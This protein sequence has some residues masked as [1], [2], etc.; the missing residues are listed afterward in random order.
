M[1]SG[2]ETEDEDGKEV[3][4]EKKEGEED[5][6]EEEGPEREENEIKGRGGH[7]VQRRARRCSD[8]TASD[9]KLCLSS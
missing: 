2:A 1:G 4:Q 5:R 7:M 3:E 6:E 9:T 8:R